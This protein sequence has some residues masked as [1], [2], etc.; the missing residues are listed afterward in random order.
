MPSQQCILNKLPTELRRRNFAN[1]HP[2]EHASR[3]P[4]VQKNVYATCA[5]SDWASTLHATVGGW[6]CT[7]TPLSTHSW[8]W[9]IPRSCRCRGTCTSRGRWP[10][11]WTSE[12]SQLR[13]KKN[14]TDTYVVATVKWCFWLHFFSLSD[15]E[16]S[17]VGLTK[18]VVS[19]PLKKIICL[20]S[21]MMIRKDRFFSLSV[22]FFLNENLLLFP[23][24]KNKKTKATLFLPSPFFSS[25]SD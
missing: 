15:Y 2:T 23:L 3:R 6:V 22:F 10:S 5:C 7:T 14:N 11:E 12:T 19:P 8:A 9:G 1:N 18:S 25:H 13:K 16:S 20:Y 24:K 4:N 21:T 17:P